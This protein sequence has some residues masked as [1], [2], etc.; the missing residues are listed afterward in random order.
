MQARRRGV[1]CPSSPPPSRAALC[2]T[3]VGID[4]SDRGEIE[5]NDLPTAEWV[6]H[7]QTIV[8][9]LDQPP[10]EVGRLSC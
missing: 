2:Q 7:D 10:R 5:N 9:G 1:V 4:D 8:A 6:L 3:D